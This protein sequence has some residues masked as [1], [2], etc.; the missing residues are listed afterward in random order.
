[1]QELVWERREDFQ[2]KVT[3]K[4]ATRKEV[5]GK[6]AFPSRFHWTTACKSACDEKMKRLSAHK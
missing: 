1:M 4:T 2:D 5:T 3:Q 6:D